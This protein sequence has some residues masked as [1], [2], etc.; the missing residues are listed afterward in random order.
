[1]IS[2]FSNIPSQNAFFPTGLFCKNSL[3]FTYCE[4]HLEFEGIDYVYCFI[5]LYYIDCLT[6]ISI[7]AKITKLGTFV[8]FQKKN[9]KFYNSF[10]YCYSITN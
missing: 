4:H 7:T 9:F 5:C 8:F 6:A 10:N 3:F 1:M 2:T